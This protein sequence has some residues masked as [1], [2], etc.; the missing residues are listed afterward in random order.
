MLMLCYFLTFQPFVLGL[1]Q[2]G[3]VSFNMNCI[4][5]L[6]LYDD[7]LSQKIQSRKLKH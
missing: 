6:E 5:I 1:G 3:V 4:Q 2:R 7:L